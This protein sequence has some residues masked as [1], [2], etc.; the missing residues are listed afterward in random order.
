MS[1]QITPVDDEILAGD[2]ALAPLLHVEP[3]TIRLWRET[4]G[5][6]FYRPTSKT[7]LFKRSD[8]MRWLDRFRTVMTS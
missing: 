4:R 7:I 1:N 5:L 8:V 2:E 6:P 3:R